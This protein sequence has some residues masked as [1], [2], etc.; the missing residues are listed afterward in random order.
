ML[1]SKERRT[2]TTEIYYYHRIR[3]LPSSTIKTSGRWNLVAPPCKIRQGT[4]LGVDTN[5]VELDS[6]G[7]EAVVHTEAVRCLL[8][9]WRLPLLHFCEFS[10]SHLHLQTCFHGYNMTIS[11][12]LCIDGGV[13][14]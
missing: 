6:Q 3:Q 7:L 13:A 8:Q 14:E 11:C 1:C 2:E 4:G 5:L 9:Q 10:V 12:L